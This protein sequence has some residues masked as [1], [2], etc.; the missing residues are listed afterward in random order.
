LHLIAAISAVFLIAV[1]L[2]AM[3]VSRLREN[4]AALEHA[5]RELILRLESIE[6]RIGQGERAS[7]EHSERL[8]GQLLASSREER[9][10][11]ARNFSSLGESQS[12]YL[13]EIASMQKNSLDGL[14]VQIA[15]LTRGNE[16]RLDTM[17]ETIENRLRDLQ[18]GNEE[19]LEKMRALVDEK[20]H[21]TLEQRLG[22]AFSNVSEW[23]DK[24]HQ[25]LGEMKNLA[26]DVGDL[27]RVLTNVKTRGIWGEIQ[28]GALLEQIMNG[29][30]YAQNVEVV[31]GTSERVEFAIK[32]PGRDENSRVW[33]PIDSKFPQEDYLRLLGA[34][35]ECDAKAAA[36]HRRALEG[37]I[38]EEAKKIH[39]KY[40][41]PPY[42]TDFAVLFLPVEGLYAEVIRI[43]G[44]CE[45]IMSTYRIVISGPTTI[46]ALLNSLQM[47]FR[48][49]AVEKRSSEVWVLLGQIKT[50]FA[51]F[52]DVL[53]KVHDK[54][55]QAGRELDNAGVRS[56]AIERKL[57]NVTELPSDPLARELDSIASLTTEADNEDNED[58]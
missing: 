5:T 28:L 4:G 31:P 19:K 44:L 51:K 57:R 25:G 34:V 2:I 54:I 52:G 49:L 23:L 33:L 56:R 41:A 42:T 7:L 18:T 47:G 8:R 39:A 32:L 26:G 9:D 1:V 45:R 50:E 53:K 11:I 29:E 20:L 46:A 43:D 16:G 27:R 3:G 6:E 12:R 17:R 13:R 22:A 10:E 15:Q 35:E 21:A 55:E 14:S 36:D 24:V 48:T 40:V 37:R 58:E 38:I 30:Q